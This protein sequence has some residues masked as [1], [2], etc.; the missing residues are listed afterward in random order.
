MRTVPGSCPSRRNP[1][2]ALTAV[3]ATAALGAG[4]AVLPVVPASAQGKGD[5][6]VVFHVSPTGSDRAKGSAAKPFRTLERAQRAV[7]TLLRKGVRERRPVD[8]VVHGGTY[9]LRST[10]NFT[11]A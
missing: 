8:V 1:A 4:L 9:R 11:A 10:L 2:S 3:V 5:A 6:A 7:R